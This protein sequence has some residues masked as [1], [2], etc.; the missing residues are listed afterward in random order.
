MSSVDPATSRAQTARSAGIRPPIARGSLPFLGHLLSFR[1]E[2]I[3]LMQRIHE[4]CGEIG[5]MNLAGHR[6]AMLY[7]AE[8][9]EAFFRA[10]DEDLAVT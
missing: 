2:P 4:E 10:P 9:Q 8:A 5:E 6:I 1:R 3:R 7:G